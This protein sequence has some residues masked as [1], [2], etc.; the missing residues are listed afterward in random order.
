MPLERPLRPRRTIH[1]GVVEASGIH[2]DASILGASRA[3]RRVV[4]AWVPGATVLRAGS[5]LLVLLPS[6]RWID[7]RRAPGLPL[8]R[9]SASPV[10]A[11]APAAPL[12][13]APLDDDELAAID[14]P[15][16]AVLLVAGGVVRAVDDAAPIEPSDLLD[17]S[18]FA[19]LAVTPLGAPPPA[20]A[21][22]A[23]A[24][25]SRSSFGV[26]T[27]PPESALL[28]TALA[29]RKPAGPPRGSI[30]LPGDEPRDD[31][32][33]G[34]SIFLGF[35]AAMAALLGRFAAPGP[36]GDPA[37][38]RLPPARGSGS[39]S[40]R[41]LAAVPQEPR[42]P[43]L[44]DRARARMMSWIA[45]ALVRAR[46][47]RMIGQR[48]SEY[49][50]Q[51]ME[52]F[53]R[54]DL[55]EALRR[56]VPL[57]RDKD[58]DSLVTPALTVPTPRSALAISPA[59]SKSASSMFASGDLFSHLRATY[60]KA[61]ERLEREGRVD[62]AAFV[63]AE[64]LQDNEEAVAFLERHGR[65]RLAA[66]IA[67]ARGLPP[68]LVVRQWFLAGDVPRAVR[69]ARRFSAFADAL[70]RLDK[71][72]SQPQLRLLW[73]DMLADAGDFAAAIDVVWPLPESRRLA[74]AWIDE[75]I[76][77]GGVAGARMLARK[78]ELVPEAFAEVRERALALLADSGDSAPPERIA[79]AQALLRVLPTPASRTLA[80]PTIR[81]LIRD[82]ARTAEPV[83]PGLVS[84]L[85]THAG[86]ASLRADVPAWPVVTRAPLRAAVPARAVHLAATDTGPSPIHDFVELPSGRALIALGEAGVRVLAR[87]GRPLFHLDQPAHRLVISDRGDR[88]LALA[89]RGDVW[90]IARLDLAQRRSSAWCEVELDA[91]ASDFDGS[92]WLVA[93]SKELHVIDALAPELTALRTLPLDGRALAI[94]R[95]PTE[96]TVLVQAEDTTRW[97]FELPSFTLRA[98]KPIREA[99]FL[100]PVSLSLAGA[101]GA[102]GALL[103][104]L[105]PD[106]PA[107]ARPSAQIVFASETSA[108][109]TMLEIVPED[110]VPRAVEV[111]PGFVAVVTREGQS[112][113]VRLLDD[114]SLT[115][116]A[117]ITLAGAQHA[118]ARLYNDALAVSDDR[119]RLLTLDLEHGGV[120]RS[121]RV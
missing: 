51:T 32:G 18:T 102:A 82:G 29:Q 25:V 13:S 45:R 49:L 23:L 7:A 103:Q 9:V 36:S 91:F 65:L 119:G 107:P 10:R 117:I 90:R 94:G 97:R 80:R 52:M 99:S 110:A 105:S 75:A 31:P 33:L 34:L 73:A 114:T 93:K 16:G 54:G 62:E 58:P 40:Q 76:T 37:P 121:Q 118:R 41:S 79:F 35:F 30:R 112:S 60:R 12:C 64:L 113:V 43:S 61:F 55:A 68:G 71:H 19:P 101:S 78:L 95:T 27:A 77:Q 85:V 108:N 115:C 88:A 21:Q 24:L 39:G 20:P 81:A 44:S 63:L 92:Q 83:V 57:A 11:G 56:A 116:R 96:C 111:R 50:D 14:P 98:R 100:G 86:D 109:G 15:P 89:P 66:E 2:V 53:E 120:L 72:E 1:R 70:A 67:E 26:A 74:A 48:Q 6:P 47:A 5:A 69:H 4:A 22:R 106:V 84:S 46:L 59:Q 87:D 104:R 17:V 3:I 8:V 42:G 38:P 28:L